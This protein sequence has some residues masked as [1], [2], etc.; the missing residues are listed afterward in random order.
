M[1][2]R[3]YLN[4]SFPH[5]A[6]RTGAAVILLAVSRSKRVLSHLA[7]VA[8]V[9]GASAAVSAEDLALDPCMDEDESATGHYVTQAV[10]QARENVSG[11]E[12]AKFVG[13]GSGTDDS[14]SAFGGNQEESQR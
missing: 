8:A 5:R 11:E 4:A 9:A 2:A 10:T 7:A 14:I 1:N 6:R 13:T 12:I 3:Q